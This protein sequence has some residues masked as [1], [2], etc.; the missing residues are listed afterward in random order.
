MI[1]FL[2]LRIIN[3]IA[4]ISNIFSHCTT[5]FFFL[6]K[7]KF[8]GL[9]FK[10]IINELH[11]PNVISTDEFPLDI[12]NETAKFDFIKENN[13]THSFGYNS[14]TSIINNNTLSIDNNGTNIC[15]FNSLASLINSKII[16]ISNMFTICNSLI[17]LPDLSKWDIS[18]A[19]DI[20]G[21]FLNAINYYHYLINQNEIK[22]MFLI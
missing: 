4:D 8:N 20:T 19:K 5:L 12:N 9:L 3:S 11:E 1:F 21:L 17:K 15:E 2:T 13:D 6:D 18:D 22:N 16:D 7:S 10:N 14:I